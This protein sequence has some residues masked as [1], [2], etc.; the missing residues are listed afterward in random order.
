MGRDWQP[1]LDERTKA[2]LAELPWWQDYTEDSAMAA[3]LLQRRQAAE[4]GSRGGS[5]TAGGGD[6]AAPEGRPPVPKP[7]PH[8]SKE[9]FGKTLR[10]QLYKCPKVGE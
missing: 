3:L 4:P 5:S 8:F 9:Y 10:P 6:G 7:L 2:C 1:D